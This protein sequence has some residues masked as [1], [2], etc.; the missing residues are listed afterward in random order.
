MPNDITPDPF[1]EKFEE[2]F[3]DGFDDFDFDE[4]D[5]EDLEYFLVDDEPEA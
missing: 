5:L 1:D 2:D 3:E 4:E